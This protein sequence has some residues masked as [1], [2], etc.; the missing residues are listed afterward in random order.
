MPAS[1]RWITPAEVKVRFDT[2]FYL[3]AAPAEARA[4]GREVEP[5]LPRVVLGDGAAQ[6]LLPGEP[7]Y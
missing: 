2:W 3:A 5:V 6:V 7:G 1:S 4:R